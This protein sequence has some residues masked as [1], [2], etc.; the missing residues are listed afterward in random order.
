MGLQIWEEAKLLLTSDRLADYYFLLKKEGVE[1]KRANRVLREQLLKIDTRELNRRWEHAKCHL[2]YAAYMRS[3]DFFVDQKPEF[4]LPWYRE[5]K[6]DPIEEEIEIL[7]Y[8]LDR[9]PPLSPKLNRKQLRQDRAKRNKAHGRC[10]N[11]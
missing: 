5:Y 11:R 7:K 1:H 10:K 4:Y 8:E 2:S 6:I 9:R 3:R